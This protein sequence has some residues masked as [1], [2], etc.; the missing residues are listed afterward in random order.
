M[1]FNIDKDFERFVRDVINKLS[2]RAQSVAAKETQKKFKTLYEKRK[3][4]Q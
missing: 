4:K 2:N 3:I 1:G